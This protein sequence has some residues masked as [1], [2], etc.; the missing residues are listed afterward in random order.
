MCVVVVIV[1]IVNGGRWTN[2]IKQIGIRTMCSGNIK[3]ELKK[4]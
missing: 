2:L 4:S 3:I 1:L